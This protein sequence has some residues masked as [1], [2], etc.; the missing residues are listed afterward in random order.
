MY[1]CVCVC[2]G[3]GGGGGGGGIIIKTRQFKSLTVSETS[4]CQVISKARD[5]K[6]QIVETTFLMYH[7][8]ELSSGQNSTT[9]YNVHFH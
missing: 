9:Q 6:N 7:F 5:E 2:V 3:G 8:L 4:S 1:V